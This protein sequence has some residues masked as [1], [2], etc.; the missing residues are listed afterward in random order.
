[1]PGTKISFRTGSC[2][3]KASQAPSKNEQGASRSMN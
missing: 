2:S 1:M 3:P